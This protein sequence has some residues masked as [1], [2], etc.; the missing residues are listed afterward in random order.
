MVA[1]IYAHY[2]CKIPTFLY[3]ANVSFWSLDYTL[4][5]ISFNGGA[6][7]SVVIHEFHNLSILEVRSSI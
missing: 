4:R 7:I 3:A 2:L 1:K 5:Y 6:T